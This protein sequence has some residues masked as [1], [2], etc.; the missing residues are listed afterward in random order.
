MD[1]VYS[2]LK[3]SDKLYIII[4]FGLFYITRLIKNQNT[5]T[6]LIG[7]ESIMDEERIEKA[8]KGN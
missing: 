2:I 5:I 4:E 8:K 1:N 3:K 7:E 6:I